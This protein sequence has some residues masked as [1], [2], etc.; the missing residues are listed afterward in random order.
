MKAA[1]FYRT[2]NEYKAAKE[3]VNDLNDTIK[4]RKHVSYNAIIISTKYLDNRNKS[5][6]NIP[7]KKP[8][9]KKYTALIRANQSFVER[10]GVNI[11]VSL[12]EAGFQLVPKTDNGPAYKG[13]KTTKR[14]K[15]MSETELLTIISVFDNAFGHGN[16]HIS[17]GP[18][19]MKKILKNMELSEGNTNALGFS[20]FNNQ[21][22]NGIPVKIKV[23]QEEA[24]IDKY[25]FKV[26][27]KV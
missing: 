9:K 2:V 26:K 6:S 20:W 24:N 22:P 7:K 10:A 27:L 4:E 25:L 23:N 14:I 8:G 19:H 17:G 5:L 13:K 3:L 16:Y 1:F 21:Y 11:P 18:R 15:I 12:I